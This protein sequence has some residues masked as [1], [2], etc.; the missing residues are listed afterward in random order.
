MCARVLHI[1]INLFRSLAS[2]HV[3]FCR[4]SKKFWKYVNRIVK[5]LRSWMCVGLIYYH[6]I[7]IYCNSCQVVCI[8]VI[9]YHTGINTWL[10]LKI[11]A[12]FYL[13]TGIK[14]RTVEV[15]LKDSFSIERFCLYLHIL[16]NNKHQRKHCLNFDTDLNIY[17]N[18]LLCILFP[19]LIILCVNI[20]TQHEH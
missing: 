7:N 5:A 13:G 9:T 11:S 2:R 17:S 18:Y 20:R 3:D 19:A 16:I 12:R 1:E 8:R 10:F 4:S 6:M 15:V 14:R